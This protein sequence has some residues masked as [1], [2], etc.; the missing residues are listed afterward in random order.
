[1][2]EHI[3]TV[4]TVIEK[5]QNVV[6]QYTDRFVHDILPESRIPGSHIT[7]AIWNDT[8][9]NFKNVYKT[10][11]DYALVE[12]SG[13]R[14]AFTEMFIPITD[15]TIAVAN[16]DNR[17]TD[18]EIR[19]NRGDF[20]GDKGDTGPVGPQGPQGE[21]GEKGTTN[22][23]E[24]EN[25]PSINGVELIGNKT[26]EELQINQMNEFDGSKTSSSNRVK[27]ADMPLGVFKVINDTLYIKN[28]AGYT[29][30][31][32]E[33]AIGTININSSGEHQL[34]AQLGNSF[35]SVKDNADVASVYATTA[36]LAKKADVRKLEAINTK[37][38]QKQDKLTAGE[39]ITIENNVIS[40][41]VV[42][43]YNNLT[44]QPFKNLVLSAIND[45][46]LTNIADGCYII[47]EWGNIKTT[48]GRIITL[49]VGSELMINTYNGVK[50]GT[51]QTGKGISSFNDNMSANDK[52]ISWLNTSHKDSQITE[53][54]NDDTIPTSKAVK[55]YVDNLVTNKIDQSAI[56]NGLK[57]T[58]GM[59]Q[60]DIPVATAS[61]TYGGDTQ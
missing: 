2:P 34:S 19:A 54:A 31:L 41:N 61:T 53:S 48:S 42:T 3:V 57:F 55:D 50:A 38:S 18:I 12:P 43:D 13:L 40:A 49:G 58:D 51:F 32:T 14:A 4:D 26:S 9:N 7:A 56:G 47:S 20:K 22:Y 21:K 60:L 36:Q 11:I 33:G 23:I 16:M 24:L 29:F 39:N 6:E 45:T 17:I 5:Y 46:M 52:L 44:N 8:I 59:L 30:P 37:V 10:I 27:L 25:K 28:S 35:I 15:A 1:M